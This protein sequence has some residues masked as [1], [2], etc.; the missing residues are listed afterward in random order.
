VENITSVLQGRA[1]NFAVLAT[2]VFARTP[3]GWRL[4]VHHATPQM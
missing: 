4:V 1:D 2:N 3:E